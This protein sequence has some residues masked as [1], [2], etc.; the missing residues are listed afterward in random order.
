MTKEHFA[1]LIQHLF[2]C[3]GKTATPEIVKS[4][5]VELINSEKMTDNELENGIR[6]AIKS[7]DDFTSTAKIKKYSMPDYKGIAENIWV[8][9]LQSIKNHGDLGGIP[10]EWKE[11]IHVVCTTTDIKTCGNKYDLE[12]LKRRFIENYI[13]IYSGVK[14]IE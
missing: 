9:A 3:K 11:A 5:Y 4:W 6:K 8:S 7:T 2:Q 13:N 14:Q 10:V 12:E 1:Q